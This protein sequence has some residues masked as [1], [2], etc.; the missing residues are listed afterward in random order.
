MPVITIVLSAAPPTEDPKLKDKKMRS[1][2]LSTALVFTALISSGCA[3]L[4]VDKGCGVDGACASGNCGSRV[5]GLLGRVRG[6]CGGCG[7]CSDCNGGG[8]IG[9]GRGQMGGGMGCGPEGC[10]LGSGMA[11]RGMIGGGMAGRGM[12]GGGRGRGMLTGGFARAG[13]ACQSCGLLGGHG[14]LRCNQAPYTPESMGPGGPD[15]YNGPAGPETG[16]VRYPYYTNRAPR[17]FL[18]ANP[19]SIGR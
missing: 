5:G 18:M 9:M 17:D 15:V 19:P 7:T 4:T 14:G 3:T 10:G 16:H 11:G 1:I 2:L 6:E 13:A 8:A 12:V